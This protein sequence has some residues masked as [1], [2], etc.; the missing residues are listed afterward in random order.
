MQGSCSPFAVG[1]NTA[2]IRNVNQASLGV[3]RS[4][5]NQDKKLII[6]Y[7]KELQDNSDNQYLYAKNRSR[8]SKL[9][10]YQ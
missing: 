6:N 1:I 9:L 7:K 10:G 8:A 3:G 4:L 5:N 2:S